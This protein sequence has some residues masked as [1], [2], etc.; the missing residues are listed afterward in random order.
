MNSIHHNVVYWRAVWIFEV[1][2]R[3]VVFNYPNC[4]HYSPSL[5]CQHEI[6][7]KYQKIHIKGKASAF[8]LCKF[9]LI[10]HG[11]TNP[12]HV[13]IS[14]TPHSSL[15]QQPKRVSSDLSDLRRLCIWWWCCQSTDNP[16][17]Q[18]KRHDI[19]LQVQ[20]MWSLASDPKQRIWQHKISI[21]RFCE[22]QKNAK[23]KEWNLFRVIILF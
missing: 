7:H 6:H 5:C 1:M 9:I 23:R 14:P 16:T 12:R 13:A 11:L 21:K 17:Y 20:S 8:F 19:A 22:E 10:I 3:A 2:S 4:I 15:K 18:R